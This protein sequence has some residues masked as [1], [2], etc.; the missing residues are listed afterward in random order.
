MSNI[1]VLGDI[2]TD[3]NYHGEVKKISPEAPIPIFSVVSKETKSGMSGNVALN[4]RRA[5]DTV[6][7]IS[8]EDF[9][10]PKTVKSRYFAQNHYLYRIDEDE[11]TPLK[12]KEK[13]SIIGLMS[14]LKDLNAVV[15]QDYNKGFFDGFMQT[16]IRFVKKLNPET[17]IIADG[18]KERTFN[19]YEGVD[20]LKLN[21]QEYTAIPES[22]SHVKRG[23]V[24]TLGE[25][26]AQLL[27]PD[28]SS[29]VVTATTKKVVD[30]TGAGDTFTSWFASEI[31]RGNT[32]EN[33][34]AIAS[35][36]AGISV[37]HLGC[38]APTRTEVQD[39]WIQK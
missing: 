24:V 32:E 17:K 3:V 33:A 1:V 20:Y 22:I 2:C 26:G 27:R 23:V 15:L 6:M 21:E 13:E 18:H 4:L 30:V 35:I 8:K 34:M 11:V 28:G 38:Y 36:A 19:F 25:R 16:V 10:Y 12:N 9:E 31:A 29:V 5:E 39:R 14:Q 7:L 37:E